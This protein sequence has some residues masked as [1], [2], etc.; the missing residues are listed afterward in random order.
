MSLFSLPD[1]A[2]MSLCGTRSLPPAHLCHLSSSSPAFPAEAH[3]V[4]G[5]RKSSGSVGQA[6]EPHPH[7]SAMFSVSSARKSSFSSSSD[8]LFRRAAL[9]GFPPLLLRPRGTL[10]PFL[11]IWV[12][13]FD[14]SPSLFGSNFRYSKNGH[15][16]SPACPGASST[17]LKAHHS[18]PASVLLLCPHSSPMSLSTVFLC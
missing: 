5:L 11:R 15:F 7:T 16:T 13:V 12:P 14:Q 10:S 2:L 9:S 4:P 18:L 3:H 1:S 6:R 8:F 17:L